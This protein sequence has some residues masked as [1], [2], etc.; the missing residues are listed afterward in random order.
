MHPMSPMSPQSPSHPPPPPHHARPG[1]E[2]LSP[3]QMAFSPSR[4]PP[5]MPYGVSPV[6]PTFGN[7]GPM[8]A[9]IIIPSHP[10][11]GPQ[12]PQQAMYSATSPIANVLMSPYAV[13]RDAPGAYAPQG[14]LPP[15]AQEPLLSPKSP[16]H[17][18]ADAYGPGPVNKELMTHH[19]RGSARRPSFGG[20]GRKPPCLFFPA[21]RCRNG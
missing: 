21:G 10:N 18:Q 13:P 6:S 11:G 20:F 9:P 17:P 3:I 19:R 15:G 12:S 2:M 14:M 8:P 7:H 16:R 5:P 4:I 1:P